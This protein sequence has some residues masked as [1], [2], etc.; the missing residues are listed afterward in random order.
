MQPLALHSNS[1]HVSSAVIGP[2]VPMP[3]QYVRVNVD[4]RT[5]Q[6]VSQTVLTSK[7]WQAPNAV[8]S[9]LL[10]QLVGTGVPQ[11]GSG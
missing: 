4:V 6:L 9:P 2:H 8:H 11:R 3:S 1:E 7:R 5:L 10:P